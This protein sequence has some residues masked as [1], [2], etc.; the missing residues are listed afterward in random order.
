MLITAAAPVLSVEDSDETRNASPG[1]FPHLTPPE[2]RYG[3]SNLVFD[4]DRLPL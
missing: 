4:D 2:D 3:L 1:Q